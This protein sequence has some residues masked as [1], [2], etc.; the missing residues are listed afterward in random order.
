MLRI[1]ISTHCI[2]YRSAVH[3]SERIS[4]LR[5]KVPVLVVNIDDPAAIVPQT[6]VG[7][8]MYTWNDRVLFM[9]NPSEAELLQRIGVFDDDTR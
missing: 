9:G 4:A 5:P 3:L 7:T 1:Y 8:P 6:I 2:G